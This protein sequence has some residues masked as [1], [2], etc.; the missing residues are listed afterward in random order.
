MTDGAHGVGLAVAQE[1]PVLPIVAVALMACVRTTAGRIEQ[2]A[3]VARTG[4]GYAVNVP[5]GADFVVEADT[6]RVDAADGSRW[7]DARMVDQ[8]QDDALRLWLNSLCEAIRWDIPGFPTAGIKTRGGQCMIDHRQYWVITSYETHGPRALLITYVADGQRVA[9]EDAWVDA[10]RTA[11]TL[12]AGPAP[13]TGPAPAEVRAT[14]RTAVAEGG[15]GHEPV[16]G[17]GELSAHASEAF[18]TAW[19][20]RAAATPPQF[21]H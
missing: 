20:A 12:S 14:L 11:F 10:W 1:A 17:G 7:F 21:P 19:A 15:V 13:L 4:P 3:I 8:P 9:Y 5:D 18:A 2:D 6:L 16:P